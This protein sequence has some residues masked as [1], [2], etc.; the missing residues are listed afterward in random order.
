MTNVIVIAILIIPW[1]I[2]PFNGLPDCTR[3]IKA[4]FF[5]LTM[6]A[7]I[8]I[9]LKDGLRFEYKNKYLA[10]FSGW[11]F[12]TFIF[13]WYYPIDRNLAY[14]IGAVDSMIHFMLS[15]MCTI[16]VCSNFQRTDFIRCGKAICVSSTLVSIF[17]IFQGI[18]L[19]PMKHITTYGWKEHRHIGALLDNPDVV[20][21]YLCMTLPLFLYFNK[22]K[23]YFCFVLCVLA[24]LFTGSSISIVS[25]VIGLFIYLIFRFSR[26]KRVVFGLLA[27]QI[28]FILF[29]FFTPSFNKVSGGFTGRMTAWKM[30]IE[31]TNNPLFGQGLGIVKSL[32][33]ITDE[34]PNDKKI[35]MENNPNTRFIAD[36]AANHWMYA[37]NDYLE[38]YCSLGALGV[39]LLALVIINAFRK[40][41]YSPDNQ[42]GF[43]YYGCFV[44]LLI[45]MLG[46]FP[47]EM[48]PI[49]L[50]GLIFFWAIS[51]T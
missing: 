44:S 31:R 33:V 26:L 39:F 8:V 13:N 35:R 9:A 21:N 22:I 38:T 18:G 46:S 27:L 49:A 19:D 17:C 23:Y 24:L 28:L 10:W 32:G 2:L 15:I 11:I 34:I 42:V 12:F 6:M 45:V 16:L 14:N 51:K 5:D 20:G 1:L 50:N 48:P 43:A 25:S 37:H 30:M 41:N 3:L 47:M 36:T 40:F 7:I 4:S 29:C